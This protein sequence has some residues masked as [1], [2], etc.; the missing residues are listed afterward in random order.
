MR[1]LRA[2]AWAAALSG[3]PSTLHALATGRDPLAATVAAGSILLP[4]E[5]SRRRLV[6][7]AAPVHLAVSLG[8]TLALD[9]AGIRTARAGAL[10]GLAIAALDLGL[11]SRGFP[12]VRALPVVPQLADHALFGAIAA[13]RL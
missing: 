10:A 7:A 13:R 2:A 11:A 9:R 8:W 4:R 12:R 6:A 5:T 3:I 1:V